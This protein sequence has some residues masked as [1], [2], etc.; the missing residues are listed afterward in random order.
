M[1]VRFGTSGG[2]WPPEKPEPGEITMRIRLFVEAAIICPVAGTM[3]ASA[4]QKS[5]FKNIYLCHKGS[6]HIEPSGF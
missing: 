5:K 4:P 6:I 3:S 1:S 2:H